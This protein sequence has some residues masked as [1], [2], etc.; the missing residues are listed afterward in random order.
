MTDDRYSRHYALTGFGK[1]AQMKLLQAGVLVVGAG[2]LGCP[3]LQYLVASG[4]GTVGI[5]DHDSVDISNLHRQVLYD[6][7]NVGH[8]KAEVAAAKLR[9]QNPD[10][11]IHA[12]SLILHPANAASLIEP[13]DIV[14][15]CTDNFAARYLLCDAC[16]LLD[17]PL[18]FGAIYQYE[19]QLAVF[20]VADDNGLKATYRHL[21]PIPP[22]PLEAPDCNTA[23]VLGVLPGLIG[24]L[25]ATEAIK[26]ITGIGTVLTNQLMTINILDNSSYTFTIPGDVPY[27]NSYPTTLDALRQFK[28]DHFCAAADQQVQNLRAEQLVTR[29]H[30]EDVLLIDVREAAEVPKL[31]VDHIRIPLS[32]LP[33]QL[34]KLARPKLVFICQTGKRSLAAAQFVAAQD[35]HDHQIFNLEG[36]IDHLKLYFHA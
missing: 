27:D 10:V 30:A 21:F 17:K 23:G 33:R 34:S 22:D 29:W 3:A 31:P 6:S 13:Y 5:V 36:G 18:I 26:L 24:T 11:T 28:Y 14:I 19:G 20:N 1:V 8:P 25:Q 4:I 12:H 35:N 16:R 7:D 32:E 2:G 9:R 15:D